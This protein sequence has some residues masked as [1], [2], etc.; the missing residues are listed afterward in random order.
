MD[1]P[2][3]SLEVAILKVFS[4][5]IW[6]RIKIF[7]GRDHGSL[8]RKKIPTTDPENSGRWEGPKF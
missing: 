7:Y 3:K 5:K 4:S 2:P 6:A 8:V 1:F